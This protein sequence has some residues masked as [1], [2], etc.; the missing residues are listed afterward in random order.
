M[1]TNDPFAAAVEAAERGNFIYGQAQVSASFVVLLKGV[2]KRTFIEGEHELKDR[3]TEIV[4][5][6]NPIEESGLT[7]LA[8]R[9]LIAQSAEFSRIVWPSLRDGCGITDLRQIE[10][11]FVKA[12]YVKNGRKWQDKKTGEDREGTTFKFH[13]IYES[14][15]ACVA[16][17]GADGNAVRTSTDPAGDAAASV[18]MSQNG[19]N[20][21]VERETIKQFLPALVKQANGNKDVLS[22]IINANPMISKYF[23]IGSPEVV[24]LMAA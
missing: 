6:I 11:K 12:E 21:A 23:N 15:T 13:A 7:Q 10:G 22:Q 14:E 20:D 8:T 18:D 17:Y 16:A 5:T 1:A 19:S 4:I 9:S 2:G 24:T 3:C